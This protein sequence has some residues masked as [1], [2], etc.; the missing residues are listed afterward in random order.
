MC[1]FFL[2]S[3]SGDTSLSTLATVEVIY[4][5]MYLTGTVCTKLKV[6]HWLIYLMMNRTVLARICAAIKRSAPVSNRTASDMAH[7]NWFHIDA[8]S[9]HPDN[10]ARTPWNGVGCKP[11]A[12]TLR[13]HSER[14]HFR[15]FPL[16]CEKESNHRL[17][18]RATGEG[19]GG[20]GGHAKW[21]PY[22]SQFI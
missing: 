18:S 14:K 20:V 2:S 6:H 7:T 16:R 3:V 21:K 22:L 5:R 11:D 10:G 12:D 1:S 8:V 19:P 9:W 13:R 15:P 17:D 4:L